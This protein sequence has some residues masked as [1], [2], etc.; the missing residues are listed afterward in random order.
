MRQPLQKLKVK[1]EKLKGR[2]EYLELI[3]DELNVKEVVF[4]VDLV[5][6][7]EL[8]ITI[9]PE[10]QKEGNVR[11]LVRAV[12]DLRKQKNLSPQDA[13]V[14]KIETDEMGESFVKEFE[15]E[16]KKPTNINE[17]LFEKN[18]GVELIIQDFKFKIQIE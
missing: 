4:D 2:E 3:K 5:E 1:S 13:I 17:F 16:I 18:T 15:A 7:I 10:L 11:D 12:Q 6:E 8:D 14:L 9:T